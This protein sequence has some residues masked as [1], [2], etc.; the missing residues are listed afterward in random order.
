M[1]AVSMI[2]DHYGDKWRDLVR[3]HQNWPITQPQIS[4]SEFDALKA[5]V[6]NLKELLRKAKEYDERTGQP[7][8]EKDEKVAIVRQVAKLVGVDLSD[9]LGDAA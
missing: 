5:E 7:D 9:V 1:C 4:R 6:E 3:P 2:S 8:C